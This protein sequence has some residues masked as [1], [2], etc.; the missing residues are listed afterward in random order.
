MKISELSITTNYFKYLGTN[1]TKIKDK[2][3][4]QT[5]CLNSEKEDY[6]NGTHKALIEV[7][8]AEVEVSDGNNLE[9]DEIR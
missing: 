9:D 4:E 6:I 7:E 5:I 8:E 1:L 2:L 3:K